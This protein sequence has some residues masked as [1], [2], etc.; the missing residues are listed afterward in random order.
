MKSFPHVV[1]A[2]GLGALLTQNA[3]IGAQQ[4]IRPVRSAQPA[5]TSEQKTPDVKPFKARPAVNEA[6]VLPASMGLKPDDP[7]PPRRLVV[8]AP[9][10]SVWHDTDSAGALWVRGDHYKASF[11]ASGATFVPYLGADS[12][13]NFPIRFTLES[14][15]VDGVET[16][17]SSGVTPTR[18]ADR[19]VY[20]RGTLREVYDVR[21]SGM[22]QLFVFDTLPARGAIDIQVGVASELARAAESGRLTFAHAR[23][24]V[25]YTQAVAVDARGERT[26]LDTTFVDGDIRIHVPAEVARRATLPL[27]VDPVVSLFE[28]D[29]NSAFSDSVPDVAYEATTDRTCYV[30]ERT[31]SGGDADVR[32][33]MFAADGTPAGGGYIDVTAVRSKNPK[34]AGN[35]GGD[36][37]LV[38]A[39]TGLSGA[40]QIQSRIIA[41]NTG[42]VAFPVIQSTGVMGDNVACDVGGDYYEGSSSKYYIVWQ[43]NVDAGDS[44]IL[45]RLV[46]MDGMP[47]GGAIGIATST[48]SLEGAPSI[49]KGTGDST[50]VIQGWNIVWHREYDPFDYDIYGA[51]ISFLGVIVTPSFNID[52]SSQNEKFPTVSTHLR[53]TSGTTE[54]YLVAYQRNPIS[55]QRDIVA[56]VCSGSNIDLLAQN[57]S[58]QYFGSQNENQ[59][60]ATADSDGRQFFLAHVE[61][62]ASSATDND[63]YVSSF[64][65]AAGALVP[66]E[67]Y[68]PLAS[69]VSDE[70]W[71]QIVAERSG[72]GTSNCAHIVWEDRGFSNDPDI[73]AG[74]YCTPFAGGGPQT[75]MCFGDGSGVSCPCGN[76]GA[77]TNGCANSANALG[78]RLRSS[79]AASVSADTLVLAGT[80]MP[81][82]SSCLYFQ[83]SSA[84]APSSF[85][86]G[87][88]CTSGVVIRLGI[89]LNVG[90]ASQY[91]TAG[92][93]RVSVRG[94]IPAEGGVR[95]Y[96]VWYRNS[97]AFCTTATFNV[98]NAMSIVFVP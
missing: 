36:N 56:T 19:I 26:L 1:T 69:D 97:A 23:G 72:G 9:M 79:G 12:P 35:N 68:A 11:D 94:L 50:T 98:T 13:R 54:P 88:R 57:L 32:F 25:G 47:V 20:E 45:G 59:F 80:N 81:A 41:A 49:S 70:T 39:E 83:G 66:T 46:G 48:G 40:R 21:T 95:T 60:A 65:Y 17:F 29:N 51:Q 74:R 6:Q 67:G 7:T 78:G 37:F 87:L 10:E 84:T 38:A 85:G 42:S 44:D 31:F 24:R 18:A 16:D 34:I 93:P 2:A 52:Y 86:D 53:H 4:A 75:P 22:E 27:V 89:K 92:D 55:G 8:P 63:V 15:R 91:P 71:P 96:Q 30:W 77:A 82:T 73:E 90:G 58:A 3:A 14:V 28:P 33:E 5:H 61:S 43:R 76:N 64:A 62:F